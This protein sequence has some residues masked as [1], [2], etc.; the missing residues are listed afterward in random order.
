MMRR[1]SALTVFVVITLVATCCSGSHSPTA[2]EASDRILTGTIL[3][4]PMTLIIVGSESASRGTS[5][6]LKAMVKFSNYDQLVDKTS[7]CIWGSSLPGVATVSQGGL[8][9]AQNVGTTAIVATYAPNVLN[10]FV[11]NV[12]R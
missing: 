6:N 7:S 11:F 4:T 1:L 5:V 8:V 10:T 12:V 2:P 3:G 9:I